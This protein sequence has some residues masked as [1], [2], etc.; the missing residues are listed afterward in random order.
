M[1]LFRPPTKASLIFLKHRARGGGNLQSFFK[2]MMT[3]AF[4]G[5]VFFSFRQFNIQVLA[6]SVHSDLTNLVYFPAGIRLLAVLLFNWLGVAGILLG[7]I[8]CNLLADEKTL[9]ECVFLGLASGL[10]AWVSLYIWRYFCR[11]PIN[12]VSLD[13]EQLLA[14]VLISSVIASITRCLVVYLISGETSLGLIFSAGFIGD[15]L[16]TLLIFYVSKFILY[17]LGFFDK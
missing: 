6:L 11:I 9:L 7:W 13:L 15:V 8:L 16:G 1:F 12:L 14:L 2:D 17:L 10:A 4:I 3:I 5:I